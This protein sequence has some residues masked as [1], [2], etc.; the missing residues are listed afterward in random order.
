LNEFGFRFAIDA[1]EGTR[2]VNVPSN[3]EDR[4]KLYSSLLERDPMEEDIPHSLKSRNSGCTL[5]EGEYGDK[6]G[7]I[8]LLNVGIINS[9]DLQN[10]FTKLTKRQ[11]HSLRVLASWFVAKY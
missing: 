2:Y 9:V 1:D 11:L 5:D 10:I 6:L 8:F 4:E 7:N 3:V